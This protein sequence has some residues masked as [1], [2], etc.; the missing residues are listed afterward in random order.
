MK[1]FVDILHEKFVAKNLETDLEEPNVTEWMTFLDHLPLAKNNIEKSY[2]KFLCRM[3]YFPVLKRVIMNILGFFADVVALFFALLS[4]TSVEENNINK[5]MLV[6]EQSRDVPDF[7]DVIPREFYRDYNQVKVVNNFNKKFGF[8]SR[9][10]RALWL[11]TIRRYPFKFFFHYWVY[12]ELAAHTAF[13]RI[14]SPEAVAVYVNERN[15]ASPIITELYESRGRRFISFMH[16]E[17]LLQLIQA[18]MKFSEYYVWDESYVEM[19]RDVLRCEAKFIPYKPNKLKKRWH[20]EDSKPNYYCT[21]YF[22]DETEKTIYEI[23]NIFQD[24]ESKGKKCKIR[25]HPR[26]IVHTELIKDVFNKAHIEIENNHEV[27]LEQSLANT[28]YAVG[29]QTTV[30]FEAVTEGKQIVIDDVSD[31]K[32]F[33]NL[34]DRWY[35]LLKCDHIL[36]SELVKQGE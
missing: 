8:L 29:M 11:S 30:L 13:L 24:F 31:P 32:H 35:R 6:L 7:N 27:S 23:A 28:K 14:Y 3:Y 15:V 20:L 12:M 9:E 33:N 5:G 17:Y 25:L 1:S 4:N 22:G 36:L 21:Y 16:G 34:Q 19:F 18:H 2:N 26:D 10:T